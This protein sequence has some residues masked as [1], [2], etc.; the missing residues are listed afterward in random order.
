MDTREFLASQ[1][2]SELQ[3]VHL[4]AIQGFSQQ[5]TTILEIITTARNIHDI[6]VVKTNTTSILLRELYGQTDF[7][8]VYN[9]YKYSLT[10][11]LL[12][13]DFKIQTQLTELAVKLSKS[14]PLSPDQ[15]KS[16]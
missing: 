5:A 12:T 8:Q 15:L 16:V 9:I 11:L 2:I 4:K 3:R 6:L 10:T 7:T 14:T 1:I 13:V